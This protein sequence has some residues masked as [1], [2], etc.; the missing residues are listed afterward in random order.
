MFFFSISKSREI[1][2]DK[3]IAFMCLYNLYVVVTFQ[4]LGRMT[5]VGQ[6]IGVWTGLSSLKKRRK[7]GLAVEVSLSSQPHVI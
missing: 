2:F 3:K 5:P 1:F 4:V 7:V 6:R